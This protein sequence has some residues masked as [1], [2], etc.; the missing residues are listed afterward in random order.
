MLCALGMRVSN[1]GYTGNHN[2]F[3]VCQCAEILLRSALRSAL[4][5]AR[6]WTMRAG[7]LAAVAVG[8][9]RLPLAA[10]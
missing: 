1:V 2:D 3:A 5:A 8:A 9:A 10:A 7:M 6:K 4:L